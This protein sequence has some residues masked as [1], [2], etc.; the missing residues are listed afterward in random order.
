MTQQ[1]IPAHVTDGFL[2]EKGK[3]S[4]SKRTV[5]SY[6]RMLWPF[7]GARTPERVTSTDVLAYAHGIGLSGRRPSSATVG[8][9]RLSQFLLPLRDPDGSTRVEP[10]R[11]TRAP[12][13]HVCACSRLLG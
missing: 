4:G 1:F 6:S 5:E 8:V 11:C 12:T 2:V 13:G 9:D 3:R 7:F 10:M